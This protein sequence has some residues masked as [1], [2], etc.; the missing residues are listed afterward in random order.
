[1]YP[2]TRTLGPVVEGELKRLGTAAES[3]LLLLTD[4]GLE[5][6][7]VKFIRSFAS[8][9]QRRHLRLNTA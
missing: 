1:M 3:E 7:T 2:V 8:L 6:V 5:D 4:L 9:N